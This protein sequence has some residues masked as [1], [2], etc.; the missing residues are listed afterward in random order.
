[1]LSAARISQPGSRRYPTQPELAP[2][3]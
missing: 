1:V 3:R 2:R